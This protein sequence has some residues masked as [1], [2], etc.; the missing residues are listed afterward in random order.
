VAL[1]RI[2]EGD[3]LVTLSGNDMVDSTGIRIL[4]K[5]VNIKSSL[6]QMETHLFSASGNAFNKFS[7]RADL[8]SYLSAKLLVSPILEYLF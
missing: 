1:C 4:A 7:H 6:F 5:D 3:S 8:L 2:D